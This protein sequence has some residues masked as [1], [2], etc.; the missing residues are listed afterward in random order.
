VGAL[1]R[2]FNEARWMDFG[3]YQQNYADLHTRALESRRLGKPVVNS[4]YGYLL[5][6]QNGD[7][8]PDK[9]NSTSL[10]SM[11]FATW[12]IVMAGA[13]VDGIQL[14]ATRSPG[15]GRGADDA[16]SSLRVIPGTRVDAGRGLTR[17]YTECNA[18]G[19]V[20]HTQ[21]RPSVDVSGAS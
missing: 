14:P 8:V 7:A 15:L 2:E 12:D 19:L 20:R 17:G 4:E 5:R 10:E 11:R 13:Y 6:D 16:V 18:A 1:F 21:F 9:D 3:D